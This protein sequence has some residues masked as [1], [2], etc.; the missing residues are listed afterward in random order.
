MR[1]R[2]EEYMAKALREARRSLEFEE[3]PVGAVVVIHDEVVVRAHWTGAAQRRLLDHAEMLA[4][5]EGE[6]SGRSRAGK[7]GRKRRFTPR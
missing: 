1:R 5:M 7:K 4:L 3:F 2:D 6:R